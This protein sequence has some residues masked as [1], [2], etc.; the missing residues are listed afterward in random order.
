MV[1]LNNPDL[2]QAKFVKRFDGLVDQRD[3]IHDEKRPLATFTHPLNNRPGSAGLTPTCR[4]L[5][6]GS[7]FPCRE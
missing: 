5:E 4:H 3:C 6:H 1:S 7:L 2:T